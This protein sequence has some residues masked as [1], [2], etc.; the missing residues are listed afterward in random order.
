MVVYLESPETNLISAD[1]SG[2]FED[3]SHESLNYLEIKKKESKLLIFL[4]AETETKL[5][6]LIDR[7]DDIFL[8]KYVD[9]DKQ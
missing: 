7:I 5:M 3:L 9:F 6:E 1:V 2:L 8:E 4:K